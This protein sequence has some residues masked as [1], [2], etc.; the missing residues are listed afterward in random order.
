MAQLDRT[1]HQPDKMFYSRLEVIHAAVFTTGF[2]L[3]AAGL[4][5]GIPELFVFSGPCLMLSAALMWMGIRVSFSGLAGR[6]LR[7][8]LGPAR[9]ASIHARA[10][11]WLMIGLA[12]TVWGV[13]KLTR[14]PH[15]EIPALPP[16]VSQ[17][18]E[19]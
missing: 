2:F 4:V 7:A 13:V 10:V 12:L 11:A 1:I 14:A 3:S 17:V 6:V 15:P 8:A 19:P 9:F 16:H 5:A 18:T